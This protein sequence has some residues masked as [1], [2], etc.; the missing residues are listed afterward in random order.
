MGCDS[1]SMYLIASKVTIISLAKT[2][3]FI[4]DKHRFILCL[5]ANNMLRMLQ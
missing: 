4:E 3:E 2:Y 1:E 5:M